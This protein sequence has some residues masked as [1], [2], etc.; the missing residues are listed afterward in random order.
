MHGLSPLQGIYDYDRHKHLSPSCGVNISLYFSAKC[1]GLE[2]LGHLVK[3][4]FRFVRNC[5]P[6][7]PRGSAILHSYQRF[8]HLLCILTSAW[9]CEI[10]IP[11]II[12]VIILATLVGV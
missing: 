1:L 4:M 8:V 3:Y 6:V 2:F 7:F 9:F 10:I 5:Q 12:I 11:V